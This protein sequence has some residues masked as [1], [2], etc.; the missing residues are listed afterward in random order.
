MKL[1]LIGWFALAVAIGLTAGLLPGME[2]NGGAVALIAI[3]AVFATINL[4]LGSVLRLLTMPISL[5]TLGLFSLVINAM[6]LAI[7]DWLMDRLDIDGFG[8][9][10]IA[11]V[12]ISVFASIVGFV[13]RP[14]KDESAPA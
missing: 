11:A 10:L 12:L 4:L 13:I 8:T 9:A 5:M 6:L 7:T 3:A 2:V 14:R 1:F